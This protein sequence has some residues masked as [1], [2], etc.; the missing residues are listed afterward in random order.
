MLDDDS[1]EDDD[2]GY[3]LKGRQDWDASKW[4]QDYCAQT[5]RHD[6]IAE[7]EDSLSG[8][9]LPQYGE[10]SCDK[11]DHWGETEFVFGKGN[12]GVGTREQCVG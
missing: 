11:S 12:V 3:E 5:S 10:R 4:D 7:M 2:E 1:E 6:G 9:W 8:T